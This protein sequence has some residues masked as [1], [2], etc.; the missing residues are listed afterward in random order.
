MGKPRSRACQTEPDPKHH[1][2]QRMSENFYTQLGS[3]RDLMTA[4]KKSVFESC[5]LF[6]LASKVARK[7]R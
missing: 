7:K 1:A 4:L 2:F 6:Y 5:T 3:E